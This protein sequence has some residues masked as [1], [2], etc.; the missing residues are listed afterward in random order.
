MHKSI[1]IINFIN[2]FTDKNHMI[3]SKIQKKTVFDKIH[4]VFLITV[5]KRIKTKGK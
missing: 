1:N 4:Y 2:E 3:F 5:L